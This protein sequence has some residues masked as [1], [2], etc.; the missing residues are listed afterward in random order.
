MKLT[1]TIVKESPLSEPDM[2]RRL[3]G[4]PLYLNM[5]RQIDINCETIES[6]LT[7]SRLP[8]AGAAYGCKAPY[9]PKSPTISKDPARKKRLDGLDLCIDQLPSLSLPFSP[10]LRHHLAKPADLVLQGTHFPLKH[11]III[12]HVR[13]HRDEPLDVFLLVLELQP[14]LDQVPSL[15]LPLSPQLRH[16]LVE[17]A[18]LMT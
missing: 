2:D 5:T 9:F 4:R 16:H 11:H 7:I 13:I 3:V 14:T 18:D 17:L 12:D 8:L 1:I 15:G 10:Q 6:P